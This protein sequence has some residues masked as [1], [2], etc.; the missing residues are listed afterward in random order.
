MPFL[1]IPTWGELTE[2]WQAYL[3]LGDDQRF[4]GALSLVRDF[5]YPGD[6]QW[7]ARPWPG[8]GGVL[9]E[10]VVRAYTAG[11][12]TQFTADG[13]YLASLTRSDALFWADLRLERAGEAGLPIPGGGT[14]ASGAQD[15]AGTIG[16]AGLGI[17]GVLLAGLAIYLL[18][19][20][21]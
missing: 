4:E 5:D 3:G 11:T 2:G 1:G 10:T 18:V 6:P 17:G 20:K 13:E 14:L 15:L 8:S 12:A 19:L 9:V 16:F 21:R 7:M